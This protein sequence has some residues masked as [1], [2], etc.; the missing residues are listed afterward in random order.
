MEE[1][2]ALPT[3][4]WQLIQTEIGDKD[5]ELEGKKFYSLFLKQV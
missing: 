2:A 5:V 4:S 3:L 1:W